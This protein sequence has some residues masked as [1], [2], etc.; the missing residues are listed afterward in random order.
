M[1]EQLQLT[2]DNEFY[3]SVEVVSEELLPELTSLPEQYIV[4]TIIGR[5]PMNYSDNRPRC[6][7]ERAEV[8]CYA[9][10]IRAKESLRE[11]AVKALW[12]DGI[13]V[14]SAGE[15]IALG[16]DSKYYGCAIDCSRTVTL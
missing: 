6:M 2:L 1:K 11:R 12:A 15:D 4:Y 13:V 9:K 16:K 8:A 14:D 10:S 7:V 5:Y 3:G